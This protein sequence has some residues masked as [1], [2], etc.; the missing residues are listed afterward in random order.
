MPSFKFHLKE[1]DWVIYLPS[2]GNEKRPDPKYG[3]AYNDRKRKKT[4]TGR[5][6][7]LKDVLDKAPIKNKYPHTVNFFL[8]SKGKGKT[9]KPDY[10][11]TKKINSRR[12]FYAFFKE[13]SL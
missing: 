4:Q 3:V 12:G 13:L 9:W 2:H 7:S 10:L 11:R 1:I 6:I 5:R 8:N